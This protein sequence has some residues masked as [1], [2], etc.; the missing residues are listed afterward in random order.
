MIVRAGMA[1]EAAAVS[2]RRSEVVRAMLPRASEHAAVHTD[3]ADLYPFIV[4]NQSARAAHSRD[5]LLRD[6]LVSAIRETR[7]ASPRST[8]TRFKNVLNTWSTGL[9]RWLVR[10]A[11]LTQRTGHEAVRK[12]TTRLLGCAYGKFSD[13][14]AMFDYVYNILIL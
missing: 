10:V 14:R 12:R 6:A 1:S 3:F 7:P 5:L 8:E 13:D 4:C 9:W 2:Y 11:K